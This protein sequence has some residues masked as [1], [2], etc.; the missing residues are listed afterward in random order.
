M[1]FDG[2]EVA[3][4]GTVA[5]RTG[6]RINFS[7]LVSRKYVGHRAAIP[8]FRVGKVMNFEIGLTPH[9]RLVPVNIEGEPPSYYICAGIVFTVV[10]V[11]YLR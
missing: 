10:C 8:V 7:Y 1:K 3:S 4:D 6:E 2:V 5:F 11:P 9:D